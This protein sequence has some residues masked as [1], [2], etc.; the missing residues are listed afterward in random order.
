MKTTTVFLLISL[1]AGCVTIQS[2][3]KSDAIPTFHRILVVTRL[4]KAPDS[5]VQ[6]FSRS[7]PAG[8]TICTLALSPLSF[9][10]PDEAIRKQVD[11]CQSDVILELAL[12]QTGHSGRYSH[13]FYEY[14]AEMKSVA[15]GQSFWKAIISVDPTYGEEVPPRSVVK[16][17]LN[18][19]IIEGKLPPSES[20]QA[21]Y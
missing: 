6:S 10:N 20:L 15:T 14:N 16:R 12:S 8:Y 21:S 17:L 18:D 2:N 7:F 13:T 11:A 4:R 9:D 3:T 5:Y 1:L 19:H